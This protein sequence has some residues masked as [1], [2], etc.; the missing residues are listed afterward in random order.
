MAVEKK[1]M[2]GKTVMDASGKISVAAICDECRF[3]E[4]TLRHPVRV[5]KLRRFVEVTWC[6]ERR[7]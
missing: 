1:C 7:Q 6:L 5:G 2:C 3:D 4:T